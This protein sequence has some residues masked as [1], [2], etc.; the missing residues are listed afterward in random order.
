[1]S[2]K[3]E[4][5]SDLTDI[6]G[7][8][9]DGQ[10]LTYS[11]STTKWS[12]STVS[13]GGGGSAIK[14]YCFY[15]FAYGGSSYDWGMFNASQYAGMSQTLSNF[16]AFATG[17]G[18]ALTELHKSTNYDATSL[19]L[20]TNAS[21][22]QTYNNNIVISAGSKLLVEMDVSCYISDTSTGMTNVIELNVMTHLAS[23]LHGS[24]NSTL[25]SQC[26]IENNTVTI[27]NAVDTTKRLYLYLEVPSSHDDYA[28]GH[29]IVSS[30]TWLANTSLYGPNLT[31]N[32]Y[33]QR[34][35]DYQLTESKETL[36]ETVS[37]EMKAELL[38]N[39]ITIPT[40]PIIRITQFN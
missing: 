6:T 9:A 25:A 18:S 38:S 39:S 8:P 17:Q 4:K 15:K 5:L 28:L 7:T 37:P 1:M 24:Q 34:G 31:Q 30:P 33:N 21:N 20:P 32:S 3:I 36:L 22:N 10:S 35:S 26:V 27:A 23:R 11:T 14:G 19:G 16:S 12:P 29:F 13:G 2:Y 40:G